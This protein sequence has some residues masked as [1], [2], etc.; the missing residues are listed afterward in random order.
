MEGPFLGSAWGWLETSPFL[1][2]E[3]KHGRELQE[4]QGDAG[5]VRHTNVRLDH[6]E[7]EAHVG[8]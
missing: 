1:Q 8:F 3:M 5:P 4:H 2:G 6:S 7:H